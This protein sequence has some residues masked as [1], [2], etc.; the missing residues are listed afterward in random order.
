MAPTEVISSSHR[1][2]NLWLFPGHKK[3]KNFSD[4]KN[5]KMLKKLKHFSMT[6]HSKDE[7]RYQSVEATTA[8]RFSFFGRVKM[9]QKK[10]DLLA[11]NIS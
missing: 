8:D 7:P 5:Q 1:K 9:K 2:R 10:F 4:F 11:E 6:S 3:R